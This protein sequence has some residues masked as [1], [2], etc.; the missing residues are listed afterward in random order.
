MTQ[1]ELCT[2]HQFLVIML[3]EKIVLLKHIVVTC[4]QSTIIV[5]WL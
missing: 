4:L 5:H 3:S 2:V 1:K